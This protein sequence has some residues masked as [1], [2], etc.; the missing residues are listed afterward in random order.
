MAARL[1]KFERRF[2]AEYFATNMNGTRA[3]LNVGASEKS[4][5]V[6]AHR[7]LKRDKV[8]AAI[9]DHIAK[10][11]ERADIQSVEILARLKDRAYADVREL[12]TMHRDCCRYCHGVDHQYQETPRERRE[13]KKAHDE[14]L[15]KTPSSQW[16]G[17]PQFD[18]MG[19]TGFDPRL[20]PNE[21]CPECHGRGVET[22]IMADMRNLSARA[23]SIYQGV[24]KT[25]NGFE[26]KMVSQEKALDRLAQIN[27]LYNVNDGPND[28]PVEVEVSGG[29]PD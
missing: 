21:D 26:V 29:L 15:S 13:R 16:G 8:K 14:L 2:V 1:T 23:A 27:G 24:R 3:A 28:G 22:V 18:E 9:Q 12:I 7:L 19:G 6:T 4:A 20:P 11:N 25:A 10:L 5:H 17:L